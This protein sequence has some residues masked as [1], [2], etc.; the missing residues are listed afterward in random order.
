MCDHP[1]NERTVLP[2]QHWAD[3]VDSWKC[4]LCGH[5]YI[6]HHIYHN[7]EYTFKNGMLTPISEREII[8]EYEIED[9]RTGK[10]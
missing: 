6:Y 9:K 3:L 5:E 1:K 2:P 10:L 7:G 8:R 4:N